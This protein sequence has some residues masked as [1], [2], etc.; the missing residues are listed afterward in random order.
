MRIEGKAK[1]LGLRGLAAQSRCQNKKPKT[2]PLGAN[3]GFG[4]R[5]PVTPNL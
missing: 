4:C 3:L 1:D 2:K 5:V